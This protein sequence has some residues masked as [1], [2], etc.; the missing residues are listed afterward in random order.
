MKKVNLLSPI[1]LLVM[2]FF[3]CDPQ[4]EEIIQN[5]DLQRGEILLSKFDNLIDV[6]HQRNAFATLTQEEKSLV[7]QTKLNKILSDN[8]L[9][10]KQASLIEE[11]KLLLVPD[12]YVQ[13]KEKNAIIIYQIDEWIRKAEKEF[14]GVEIYN[15]VYR[16]R[17]LSQAEL[18]AEIERYQ[19]SDLVSNGRVEKAY[20]NDCDC[21][22]SS[23][24]S[25]GRP[26]GLWSIEYGQCTGVNCTWSS[27]GCGGFFAYEC[28]GDNCRYYLG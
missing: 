5:A 10:T 21:N 13:D 4:D 18:A 19:Q 26:T 27:W 24:Y 2:G 15:L 8:Q 20:S 25:C 17:S 11:I 12:A 9:T 6:A 3:A 23:R 14:S 1:F 22:L 28:N 7:W 16:I